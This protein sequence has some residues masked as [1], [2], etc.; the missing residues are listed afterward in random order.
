MGEN[1]RGEFHDVKN[2]WVCFNPQLYHAVEPIASGSRRSLALF[3]PKSWKRLP[4]HCLDDLIDI[5]LYRKLTHHTQLFL[6]KLE[7]LHPTHLLYKTPFTLLQVQLLL[8][9]LQLLL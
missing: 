6:L 3:T 2:T 8:V 9:Q 7:Q 1:L 4:P 5:G